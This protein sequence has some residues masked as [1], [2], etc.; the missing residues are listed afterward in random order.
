MSAEGFF[1]T[2]P[3]GN[4]VDL[5]ITFL[6]TGGVR[7]KFKTLRS[8]ETCHVDKRDVRVQEVTRPPCLEQLASGELVKDSRK[9]PTKVR[10][11]GPS[12]S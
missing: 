1:V 5:E 8:G 2:N 9:P 10:K 6:G 7:K 4:N 12:A 11:I 3:K